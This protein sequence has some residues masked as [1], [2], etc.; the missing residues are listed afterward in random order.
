[1]GRIN[2]DHWFV[3]ENNLTISLMNYHVEIIQNNDNCFLRIKD[4]NNNE[5]ILP[6]DT[7]EEAIFVTENIVNTSIDNKEIEDKYKDFKKKEKTFNVVELTSKEVDKAIIDYSSKNH[8]HKVTVKEELSLVNGK[9]KIDFY[10]IKHIDYYGTKKDI[11]THLT[12]DDLKDC[13]NDYMGNYNY[14]VTDF[15][16][17]GGIHKTGY[18]IDENTPHYDGIQ[19]QVKEKKK[20]K[21]LKIDNNKCKH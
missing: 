11:I 16:Y 18:F 14:E 21:S 4:N 20:S 9:L 5:I 13:L 1:M 8:N 15:K 3:K 12:E 10:S 7:L 19:I 6:T 17:I 2:L